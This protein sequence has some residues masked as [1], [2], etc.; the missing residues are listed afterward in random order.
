MTQRLAPVVLRGA[1]GFLDGVP[2]EAGIDGLAEPSRNAVFAG[3]GQL[4]RW[5]GVATRT[6]GQ[7]SRSATPTAGAGS[8]FLCGGNIA[9]T[10]VRG[11]ASK[12]RSNAVVFCGDTGNVDWGTGAKAMSTL[13]QISDFSGSVFGTG[14]LGLTVP[15]QLTDSGGSAPGASQFEVVAGGGAGNKIKKSV[16][17]KLSVYR[18]ET[19][20]EGWTSM[21]SDIVVPTSTKGAVTLN[22]PAIAG[23]GTLKYKLYSTLQGFPQGPWFYVT[24]LAPGTSTVSWSDAQ[25]LQIAPYSSDQMAAALAADTANAGKFGL[26][27]LSRFVACL[28]AHVIAIGCWDAPLG[29]LAHASTAFKMELFDP[30]AAIVISPPEPIMGVLDASNDGYL[31]IVQENAVTA[32]VL[33]GSLANPIISRNIWWGIGGSTVNQLATISGEIYLWSREKGLVRSGPGDQPDTSF[34]QKVRDFLAGFTG[35]PI[36]GYDPATD[37]VVIAGNHA[38]Y[39]NCAIAYERG[40]PGDV[41]STPLALG[42]TPVS[43]VTYHNRLY[44]VSSSGAFQQV[45][46]SD[47]AGA[48]S[49]IFQFFPQ[50]GGAPGFRKSVLMYELAANATANVLVTG[51]HSNATVRTHNAV[52]VTDGHSGWRHTHAARQRTF[53]GRVESS[54]AGFK[55]THLALLAEVEDAEI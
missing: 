39:G 1:E 21:A 36:I 37:R 9:E 2:L 18:V 12:Y 3:P 19:R 4:V 32:I 53:S 52:T 46:A 28:G 47:G 11:S 31:I 41:W 27:P 15:A 13:I 30:D 26:P 20:G 51:G 23:A 22:L 24:T 25:L 6:G 7:F 10:D 55:V 34:T 54:A 14:P 17:L 48:S 43:R 8:A 45:F 16:S 44:L 35:D 49:S 5:P 50:D 42:F 33:S 40:L 29:H 38:T